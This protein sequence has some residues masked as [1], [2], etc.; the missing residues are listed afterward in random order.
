MVLR[1][2]SPNRRG[3]HP[4]ARAVSVCLF[5]R[6]YLSSRRSLANSRSD[7]HATSRS[8]H[9]RRSLSLP[10]HPL[11][12]TRRSPRPRGQGPW[13]NHCPQS[14]N[15]LTCL[16]YCARTALLRGRRAG[17]ALSWRSL[18]YLTLPSQTE[19]RSDLSRSDLSRSDNGRARSPISCS[20][21]PSSLSGF[22]TLSL[23]TAAPSRT[24]SS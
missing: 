11:S 6:L 3:A 12:L 4:W 16:M 19:T 20:D 24:S 21:T 7:L 23:A 14:S 15:S 18:P 10:L 1:T 22:E 13:V 8:S 9:S 17:A 5:L 2:Q